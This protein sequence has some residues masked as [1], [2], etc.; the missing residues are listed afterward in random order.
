MVL[1]DLVLEGA[2]KGDCRVRLVRCRSVRAHQT[3]ANA[4]RVADRNF[5]LIEAIPYF[6]TIPLKKKSVA[7][8]LIVSIDSF[9][10]SIHSVDQLIAPKRNNRTMPN[11]RPGRQ[12]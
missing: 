7:I 5:C 8:V 11:R 4:S 6:P 2:G 12:S 3:Y 1:P 10:G 9:L